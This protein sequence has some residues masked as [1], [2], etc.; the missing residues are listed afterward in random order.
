MTTHKYLIKLVLITIQREYLMQ[1]SFILS[2]PLFT[3]LWSCIY[4]DRDVIYGPPFMVMHHFESL[5]SIILLIFLNFTPYV[6]VKNQSNDTI[7]EI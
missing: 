4:R 6:I 1:F 7:K 5:P 2:T 3:L